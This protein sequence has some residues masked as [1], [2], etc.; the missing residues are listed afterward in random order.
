MHRSY[1]YSLQHLVT[2][3][4]ETDSSTRFTG[5]DFFHESIL[6]GSKSYVSIFSRIQFPIRRDL[7][8]EHDYAGFET[9]RRQH[10]FGIRRKLPDSQTWLMSAQLCQRWS[11]ISATG[12]ST[13]CTSTWCWISCV[14]DTAGCS[15]GNFLTIHRCLRQRWYILELLKL[16][17]LFKGRPSK[18]KCILWKY[19]PLNY[20]KQQ[21]IF[22]A[23]NNADSFFNIF[24]NTKKINFVLTFEKEPRWSL[25]GIK[26]RAIFLAL[27]SLY[28]IFKGIVSQDFRPLVFFMNRTHLVSWFIA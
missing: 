3:Q 13:R 24:P 12:G 19:K 15:Y 21:K 22:A 25:F 4:Y 23:S 28:I 18:R 17:V 2:E 1:G 20:W 10:G 6:H 26:I 27:L 14:S 11:R 7:K 16:T 5:H 8:K 9:T